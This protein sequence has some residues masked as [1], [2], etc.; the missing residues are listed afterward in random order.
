MPWFTFNLTQ[1]NNPSS[2]A[3]YTL[4][5]QPAIGATSIDLKIYVASSPGMF[6]SGKTG[7]T[8]VGTAQLSFTDCGHGTLRYQFDPS[9]NFGIGGVITLTRLTP[10]TT[11]CSLADGSTQTVPVTAPAQGFDVRQSGSWYDPNTSGQGVELTVV[12]AGNGSNGLLFGAWFTYDP[13]GTGDDPLNQYWFTLQGDLAA[14]NNGKVT[15][16]ILQILGG[17]LDGMPT[18][19]SSQVGTATLTFSACDHAQLDYQFASSVVAH[20][21]AGLSGTLQLSKLGGCSPP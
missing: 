11:N 15:L 7:A 8:Q 12:P 14:A 10:Q 19:N 16:P 5:G 20:A 3:W 1:A 2:N 13:A 18:R 9:I 21:Y 6:N 17:T 4:Q